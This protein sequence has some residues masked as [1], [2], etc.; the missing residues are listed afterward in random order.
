MIPRY[1]LPEMGAIWSEATRFQL[2]VEVEL[3]VVR[4]RARRGLVPAA[5]LSAI[6]QAPIP[7]PE[8]VHQLDAELHHDVIAFLTAYGEGA[9]QAARHVHYGMTSSD[10]LDTTLAL[11]LVRACD[12]R[13][14]RLHRL[15]GATG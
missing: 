11:Q 4:A 2:F 6:E 7:S 8:R 15:V 5:D 1:T 13:A 3:A 10:L 12:L 9:G 14:R